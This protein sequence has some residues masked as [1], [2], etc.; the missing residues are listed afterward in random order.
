MKTKKLTATLAVFAPFAANMATGAIIV[1]DVVLIDFGR[2][3]ALTTTGNWNN[4][5]N[6][7]ANGE[8]TFGTAATLAPDL[9]RS[10]DG[11]ATGVS[12]TVAA[13]GANSSGIGGAVVTPITGASAP[14]FTSS[15]TIPNTAQEDLLFANSNTVVLTF[16]GLD[17][18]LNYNVEIL[19]NI[20][21]G[22]N[23]QDISIGGEA[24]SIDPNVAPFVSAFNNLSTDGSGNLLIEFSSAGGGANL[25]HINAL[26]LTAIAVPE[27][28]VSLLGFVA[29]AG[30]LVRRRK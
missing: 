26:E 27:P 1:S 13:A 8:N 11:A 25:Q 15:G 4:V 18:S 19:S 20:A 30:L 7:G 21:A 28:S 12:L 22:R 23:A 14:S 9:V 17:D 5:N 2:T 29:A 6:S 24:M 3:A 16:L 10:S